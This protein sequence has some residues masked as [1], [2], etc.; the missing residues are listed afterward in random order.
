MA[1]VASINIASHEHGARI[2]GSSSESLGCAASHVLDHNPSKLWLTD[3]AA[4]LPHHFVIE[5]PCA[6]GIVLQTFGWFCWHAYST[7]P[8]AFSSAGLTSR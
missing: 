3:P 2:V 7:N 8:G 6:R 4:K 5:V 1:V